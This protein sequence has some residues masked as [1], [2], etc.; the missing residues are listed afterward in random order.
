MKKTLVLLL[1]FIVFI[2][3]YFYFNK[4]QAIQ[5]KTVSDLRLA[6]VTDD[7]SE[8]RGDIIFHN[9]NKMRAELGKVSFDV[10]LNDAVIGKISDNFATA[11]KGDEDFHYSFQVRF[12]KADVL[13]DDSTKADLPVKVTGTAGSDV[14]FANYTFTI[15]Y[16][17]S[18]KNTAQ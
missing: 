18:V 11:I 2:T 1:I 14:L 9:P 4:P 13:K 6:R 5:F 17:G 15:D 3:G 8:L 7:A 12:P 16:S 10:V